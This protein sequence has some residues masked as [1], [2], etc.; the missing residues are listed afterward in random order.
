M[1]IAV[2]ALVVSFIGAQLLPSTADSSVPMGLILGTMAAMS[3]G[4]WLVIALLLRSSAASRIR[5][6]KPG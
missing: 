3:V 5:F 6:K 2:S 1:S 4:L